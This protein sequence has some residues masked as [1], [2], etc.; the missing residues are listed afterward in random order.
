VFCPPHAR[1]LLM[2]RSMSPRAALIMRRANAAERRR[3]RSTVWRWLNMRG[4]I[5]PSAR[6]HAAPFAPA[7]AAVME[8]DRSHQRLQRRVAGAA[9]ALPARRSGAQ[10]A[11]AVLPW[12][13]MALLMWVVAWAA[14]AGG[15]AAV[16]MRSTSCVG[17]FINE[18]YML[19]HLKLVGIG[20]SHAAPQSRRCTRSARRVMADHA[21]LW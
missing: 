7:F 16:H 11:P 19:R 2:F 13:R 14:V 12:R 4:G 1:S 18:R 5:T 10:T 6:A 17:A 21:R 9:Q 8:A 15:G 3:V 20:A